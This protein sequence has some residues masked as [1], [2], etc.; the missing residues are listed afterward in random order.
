MFHF[1][2]CFLCLDSVAQ[3]CSSLPAASRRPLDVKQRTSLRLGLTQY[4]LTVEVQ[5][6]WPSPAVNSAICLKITG[7]FYIL[8][9]FS[10]YI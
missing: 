6:L 2:I 5:Q 4:E 1:C 8:N 7:L 10:I 9:T 3:P